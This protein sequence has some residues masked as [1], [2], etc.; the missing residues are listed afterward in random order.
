MINKNRYLYYSILP[1]C[2]LLIVIGVYAYGWETPGCDP[3]GCILPAP[4]NAGPNSQTKEGDLTIQGN[5][6]TGSFKMTTGAGADKVLS[7]DASGLA[8]WQT[9]ASSAPVS[10]VFG[11]TGAVTAVSG[12]YSVG[13]ITGAAPLASPTFTGTVTVPTPLVAGAAATKGY[14]DAA[15]GGPRGSAVALTAVSASTYNHPGAANYCYN[16]S[17]A[18][19]FAMDGDTTTSYTDWRMPTASELAQFEG[20]ASLQVYLWTATVCPTAGGWVVEWLWVGNSPSCYPGD[21]LNK[22]RCVR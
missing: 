5:L 14:V 16:L 18:A 8:S 2:L 22:I 7:S 12:D 13:N 4:I 1:C 20:L 9:S 21:V 10:S 17:A 19:Q 3:P 6:T 15:V 11:R